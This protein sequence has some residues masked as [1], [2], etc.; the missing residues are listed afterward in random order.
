MSEVHLD[1]PHVGEAF[2]EPLTKQGDDPNSSP[3]A[4]TVSLNGKPTQLEIDTG[5]E[6]SVISQKGSQ[7]DWK[8][9]AIP[10]AE[11]PARP[12]RLCVAYQGSLHGQVAKGRS[13]GGT[14]AVRC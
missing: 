4:V 3:Q 12:E 6:V 1:S 7:R 10:S 2:W 8:S 9:Q 11:N 5:A 14:G 13:R